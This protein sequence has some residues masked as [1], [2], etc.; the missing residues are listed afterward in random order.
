L[1]REPYIGARF[2]A[3]RPVAI[4]FRIVSSVRPISQA[5]TVT[6]GESV[7]KRLLYCPPFSWETKF[8][9]DGGMTLG[10]AQLSN[11]H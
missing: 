3:V 2:C 5:K 11:I 4:L 8:V 6:I 10:F 1:S 7:S 9:F